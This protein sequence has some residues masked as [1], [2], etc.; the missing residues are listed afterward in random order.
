MLDVGVGG[1]GVCDVG[2]W[3]RIGGVP[4][5][6]F[7]LGIVCLLAFWVWGSAMFVRQVGMVGGGCVGAY[8]RG[9]TVDEVLECT[10]F[11]FRLRYGLSALIFA[12][13]SRF[14]GSAIDVR[15]GV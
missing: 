14:L 2:Q 6:I 7:A 12:F 4:N 3:V 5:L 10:Y 1:G 15:G 9:G 8:G 11:W 13:C